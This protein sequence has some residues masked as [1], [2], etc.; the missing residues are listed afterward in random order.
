MFEPPTDDVPD[1]V[2]GDTNP[3]RGVPFPDQR[4]LQALLFAFPASPS[5]PALCVLSAVVSDWPESFFP[6]PKADDS[7]A[8]CDFSVRFVR[9]VFDSDSCELCVGGR[10]D[11]SSDGETSETPSVCVG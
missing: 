9:C 4:L 6:I 7:V 1:G 11:G 5:E 10:A 2:L 8:P 3:R